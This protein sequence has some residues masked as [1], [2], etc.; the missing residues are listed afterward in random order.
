MLLWHPTRLQMYPRN[1]VVSKP[2]IKKVSVEL[3]KLR[4]Q[5][6]EK[7]LLE[8]PHYYWYRKEVI[9]SPDRAITII[10][11]GINQSHTNVPLLSKWT[12]HKTVSNRLIGVKVLGIGTRSCTCKWTISRR[13]KRIFFFFGFLCQTSFQNLCFQ[14]C[15]LAFSWGHTHEEIDQFF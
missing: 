13:I 4:I 12:S 3:K 10:F 14:K 7:Q 1:V 5:H 15:M 6:V 8:T 2:T 9:Q 11:D